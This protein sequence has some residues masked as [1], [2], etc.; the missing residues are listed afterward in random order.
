[1]QNSV[2]YNAFHSID[3]L[4]QVYSGSKWQQIYGGCLELFF[5]F[6]CDDEYHF[7]V[8]TKLNHYSLKCC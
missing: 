4:N 3:D 6:F 5:F 1:M 8:V 2:S 7:A